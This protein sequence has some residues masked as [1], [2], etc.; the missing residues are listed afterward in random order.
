MFSCIWRTVLWLPAAL[1]IA[2]SAGTAAAADVLPRLPAL[3][4]QRGSVTV[5]GLSSGGY[6][7]GQFEVAYSSSVAGAAVLAGGP[8]GCSRGAVSTALLICSCPAETSFL[9]SL[10]QA[11]GGGCQTFNPDIYLVFSETAIQGNQGDIDDIRHLKDHRVWLL[12]GG[13]DHVVDRKLVDAAEA[14]YRR[15]GVPA[16]H[17]HHE[18][19]AE[20]GHGLPTLQ[21]TQACSATQA[22]YLTRCNVDAAGELLQWLY[23]GTPVLQAG[24]VD[25]AALKQFKQTGYGSKTEFDGMDGT[26][27]VYVP[28][29]CE[30][31][32]A[33]C[34][35]H[36]VFHGC[37]QGQSFVA[38]GKKF[39]T[40]FVKGAGYN[41]WAEASHIVVL[42]PQVKPSSGGSLSQPYRY[43]PKG[44]WDFWGYTANGAALHSTAPNFA[45]RSAPQMKRVKAMV[46]DLMR[47]P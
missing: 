17:I 4:L 26:G 24:P 25:D 36:V 35:L 23:P 40:Q 18:D 3:G 13:N 44:C 33:Q 29:A 7:A 12:S 42:Y 30:Q 46:D 27:W 45:A 5:S 31:A 8:Y 9:L 38:K 14:F 15:F 39:G 34:R 43:N 47:G 11:L 16:S 6:M 10:S 2:L 1:L 20:A 37:E 21:A 19:I 41:Q 22:P 28:K 32:G